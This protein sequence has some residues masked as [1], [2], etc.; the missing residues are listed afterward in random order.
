IWMATSTRRNG[1]WG[2]WTK[3]KIKGEKG[4]KGDKGDDGK[5]GLTGPMAYPA[6]EYKSGVTYSSKNGARPVVL[7]DGEYYCLKEDITYT[8]TGS[9]FDN[10]AMEYL[11]WEHVDKFSTIFADIIMANFAKLSS[12]VFYGDFMFS[13]QGKDQ[14]GN[15]TTAY[16]NFYETDPMKP[17]NVFRPNF[18]LN[19]LTGELWGSKATL[20][21]VEFS[22][23]S[24]EN[25]TPFYR[26]YNE[27]EIREN[28]INDTVEPPTGVTTRTKS[29]Q[30]SLAMI[31][32]K[33]TGKFK[34][35]VKGYLQVAGYADGISGSWEKYVESTATITIKAGTHV[36]DTKT[37]S[38]SSLSEPPVDFDISNL[39]DTLYA[40]YKYN[41]FVDVELS[42]KRV[43]TGKG[44]DSF[45]ELHLEFNG[46]TEVDENK[47]TLYET[48]Y[49][50]D[51]LIISLSDR[52]YMMMWRENDTD[53][54]VRTQF[55][56]E[57]GCGYGLGVTNDGIQIRD[58]KKQKLGWMS[59][60]E[61]INKVANK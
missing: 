18:L 12:A 48:K 32:C 55:A 61:Y 27:I 14:N 31:D 51:G 4:D 10:P 39:S 8:G 46:V 1:V 40:G 6:G 52:D 56:I 49:L 7:Y 37:V 16:Q 13:Q 28:L 45:A 34:F 58:V 54:N 41:L 44:N 23:N 30:R 5:Q 38:S 60:E 9:M 50:K 3:S 19:L 20:G 43:K 25:Y 15:N 21:N 24:I 57:N 42:V 36:L 33:R 59:L 35:G 29:Y 22:G 53:G 26:N 47:N 11:A 17:S 2:A